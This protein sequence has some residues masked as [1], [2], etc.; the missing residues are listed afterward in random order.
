MITV[1]TGCYWRLA[2]CKARSLWCSVT[3]YKATTTLKMLAHLHQHSLAHSDTKW[4]KNNK[5]DAFK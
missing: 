4:A 1:N 5:S 3:G 2:G